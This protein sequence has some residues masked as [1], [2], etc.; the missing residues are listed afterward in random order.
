[1]NAYEVKAHLIG[2][3]AKLGTVCFWQ[4]TLPGPNLVVAVLAWQTVCVVYR[5]PLPLSSAFDD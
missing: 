4:P 5:L 1:M 2:L 3:L